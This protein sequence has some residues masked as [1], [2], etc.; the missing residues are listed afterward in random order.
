MIV[1]SETSFSVCTTRLGDFI[2]ATRI[3]VQS[4]ARLNCL[5]IYSQVLAIE[6]WDLLDVDPLSLG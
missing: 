3:Y 4:A 2:D 6:Q 1:G 5:F